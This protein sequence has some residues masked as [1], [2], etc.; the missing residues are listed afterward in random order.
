MNLPNELTAERDGILL[1]A[2]EGLQRLRAN[3]YRFSDSPSATRAL[4]QY[5]LESSTVLQFVKQCCTLSPQMEDSR[6]YLFQLYRAWCL[7]N[8]LRP[9]SNPNF[10]K[11][12]ERE[13]PQ[14]V[15][16]KDSQTKRA[17]W[18]GI[19]FN[20]LEQRSLIDQIRDKLAAEE[21]QTLDDILPF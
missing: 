1:W 19:K 15:F 3:G 9:L 10:V 20:Y 2:I 5:R 14:L 17:M 11:E 8:G 16:R 13:Y 6:N 21:S 7:Q 4:E 12:M 18:C